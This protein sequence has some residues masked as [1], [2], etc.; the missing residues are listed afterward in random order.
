LIVFTLTNYTICTTLA[1]KI[2]KES[3]LVDKHK[4]AI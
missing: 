3:I 4:Y 1:S 2:Y